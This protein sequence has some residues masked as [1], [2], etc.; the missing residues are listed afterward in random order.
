[1]IY[2]RPANVGVDLEK[3]VLVSIFDKAKEALNSDKGEE[4]TD[5]A[6]DAVEK[7]AAEKLGAD[8]ADKVKQAREALDAK[9]GNEGN[10][11]TEGTEAL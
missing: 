6:F 1:M 10:T 2:R 5:K 4:I 9:I 11:A 3:G 8:K 7:F